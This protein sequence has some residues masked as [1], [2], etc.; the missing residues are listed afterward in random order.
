MASVDNLSMCAVAPQTDSF[1]ITR[2][3]AAQAHMSSADNIIQTRSYHLNVEKAIHNKV[4]ATNK[5]SLSCEM[6][7]GGLCM[8]LSAAYYEGVRSSIHQYLSDNPELS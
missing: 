5:E 7:G 1:I 2:R 4:S 6:T 3:R 8:K